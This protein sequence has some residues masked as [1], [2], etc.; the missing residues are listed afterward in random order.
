VEQK[1]QAVLAALEQSLRAGPLAPRA[2]VDDLP[3][4]QTAASEAPAVPQPNDLR[5]LPRREYPY[6]QRIAPWS[7]GRLPSLKSFFDVRCRDI[8]A[9]GISF[10]VPRNPDFERFVIGLG[11]GESN[12]HVVAEVKH[13][14]PFDLEGRP[15]Y[16]VGSQFLARVYY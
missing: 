14:R 3:E 15:L 7:G 1:N 5:T 2:V 11:Q 6:M 12:V 8:S 16:L 9:S 13:V 10:F 4:L